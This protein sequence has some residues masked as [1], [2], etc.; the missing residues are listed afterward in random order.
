MEAVGE[1]CRM[2]RVDALTGVTQKTHV[3]AGKAIQLSADYDGFWR[4]SGGVEV[5]GRFVLPL[6]PYHRD[7]SEVPSKRRAEFRRRQTLIADLHAQIDR[8]IREGLAADA[9]AL[10]LSHAKVDDH[11][12]QPATT[13]ATGYRGAEP[14]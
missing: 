11:L 13:L 10:R 12:P 7:I 8:A 3:S 6:L 5:D 1:L 14:A 9:K 2:A 4:E